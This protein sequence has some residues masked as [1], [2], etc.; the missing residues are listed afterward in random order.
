MMM[1]MTTMLN[2]IVVIV[3]LVDNKS[4]I[5]LCQNGGGIFT[6]LLNN[7]VNAVNVRHLNYLLIFVL[8]SRFKLAVTIQHLLIICIELRNIINFVSIVY[9]PI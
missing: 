2:V 4:H 3:K 1:M 8:G 6:T 9:M 7:Y 5:C